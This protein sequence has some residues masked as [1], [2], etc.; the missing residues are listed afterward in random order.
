MPFDANILA[1]LESLPLKTLG[2]FAETNGLQIPEGASQAD[3]IG[4]LDRSCP[5][6]VRDKIRSAFLI[7]VDA[8]GHDLKN[9]LRTTVKMEIDEGMKGVGGLKVLVGSIASIVGLWV[10]VGS[11]FTGHKVSSIDTDLKAS[12]QKLSVL[13][14][15][16][17]LFVKQARAVAEANASLTLRRIISEIT[18]MLDNFSVTSEGPRLR[19]DL[20]EFR[21]TLVDLAGVQAAVGPDAAQALEDLYA[22]EALLGDPDPAQASARHGETRKMRQLEESVV[23]LISLIDA[24][25]SFEHLKELSGEMKRKNLP[26]VTADWK[27][28]AVPEKLEKDAFGMFAER[29][30]IYRSNV[31]GVLILQRLK[32]AKPDQAKELLDEAD[33]HFNRAIAG[34][35]KVGYVFTRPLS[36]KA[37]VLSRRIDFLPQTDATTIYSFFRTAQNFL[38]KALLYESSDKR[39]SLLLNN[40]ASTF[41]DEAQYARLR[42][43]LPKSR[44]S[45]KSAEASI[46]KA[47][48]LNDIHPA[49]YGTLAEIKAEALLIDLDE[50]K[51]IKYQERAHEVVLIVEKAIRGGY[52]GWRNITLN[53]FFTPGKVLDRLRQEDSKRGGRFVT[54]IEQVLTK[55]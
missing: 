26:G 13:L 3:I 44:E 27:K 38:E 36:N 4:E 21:T 48:D 39:L 14:G 19:S 24:L 34:A 11:I 17:Q 37:L 43:D 46:K 45:L 51:K 20:Q 8:I 35:T 18:D 6:A 31:L 22:A 33:E 10:L 47:L 49:V 30:D 1:I 12:Q 32:F 55:K 2:K 5:G 41:Q 53:E 23:M 52:Q 25:L 29:F 42:K 15:T 54:E 40:Q 9:E 16:A 50:G 28:I 7:D